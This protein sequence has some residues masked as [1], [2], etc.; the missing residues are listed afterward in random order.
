[1]IIIII[2]ITNPQLIWTKQQKQ[3]QKPSNGVDEEVVE[4]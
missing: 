2:T 4:I 3:Q 1:M